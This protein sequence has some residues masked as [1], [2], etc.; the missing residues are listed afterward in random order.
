MQAAI[1][2]AVDTAIAIAK[3]KVYK[4]LGKKGILTLVRKYAVQKA[5]SA[6][7]KYV[8]I[9]G[10]VVAAGLAF[11]STQSALNEILEAMYTTA[12]D[13]YLEHDASSAEADTSSE[14][15][16]EEEEKEK[17]VDD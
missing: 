12:K 15:E 6:V 1:N 7:A 4:F 10:G 17:E 5:A 13:I 16:E 9:V 11:Y 2:E 8:P 14:E 3:R